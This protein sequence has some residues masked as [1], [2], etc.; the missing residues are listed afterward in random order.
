MSVVRSSPITSPSR[1]CAAYSPGAGVQFQSKGRR[2]HT[3]L[4]RYDEELVDGEV[5][6]VPQHIYGE[7]SQGNS[8][9]EK[10]AMVHMYWRTEDLAYQEVKGQV[11]ELT[12]MVMLTMGIQE[13]GDLMFT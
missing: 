11:D 8:Q 12:A 2:A 3:E 6:R 13:R 10:S 5:L 4:I 7:T 1:S 9:A